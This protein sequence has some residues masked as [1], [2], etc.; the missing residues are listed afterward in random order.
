MS[1]RVEHEIHTRRRGR[2][3]GVALMLVAFIVIIFGLTYVKITYG[4]FEMPNI[5]AQG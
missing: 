2:N 4:D 5:E 3:L 1:F